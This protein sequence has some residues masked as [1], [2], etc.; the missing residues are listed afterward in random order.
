MTKYYDTLLWEYI[1]NPWKKWLSLDKLAEN[2]FDYKMISY[3][4]ITMK[5]RFTFDEIDL[6][7]A[8]EY[9]IEDVFITNKLFEKQKKDWLTKDSVLNDIE[10][11]LMEVLK[12]MELSWV[13]IDKSLLKDLWEKIEKELESLEKSIYEIAWKEFNIKSPKQVWELL[14]VDMWLPHGKK[15]KTWYSVDTE[16]LTTLSFSNE[17]AK[18]IL[19]F[20]HLSKLQSTYIEG[21]LK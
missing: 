7:R 9:S 13:K 18:K 2:Y 8:A 17:I 20:R 3:D 14:F 16:V 11:P 15:T 6:E 1:Q 19:D 4:D 5:G 21:L 10:I 12:D